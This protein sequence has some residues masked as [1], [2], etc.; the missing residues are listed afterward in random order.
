M[1]NVYALYFSPTDTTKKTVTIISQKI[2]AILNLKF[3]EYNFTYPNSRKANL[4]FSKDDLIVIGV[5]VIAGR[6]PNLIVD[7]LNSIRGNGAIAVGIVLYGNRAY[8]DALKE[9]DYILKNDNFKVV[10]A[11]AFVGEHSFSNILAKGRPDDT[12]VNEMIEF[13]NKICD[14]IMTGIDCNSEFYIKG[15]DNIKPHFI[16]KDDKNNKIDIRKVIPKTSDSCRGCGLCA[17]VCPL[18]SIS[19]DDFKT[20]TGICMKCC[21]CVKK[22]PN[23]AKYFDDDWFLYHKNDLEDKYCSIRCENDMFL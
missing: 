18:G 2:S 22:C 9:L 11:G 7:Y 17:E 8:D 14:K 16:P 19:F 20:I 3:N 5:P 23:N 13:S 15:N 21:A 1:K 4:E 12:D 10:A 6:V